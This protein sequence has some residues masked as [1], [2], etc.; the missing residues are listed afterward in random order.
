MFDPIPSR[1]PKGSSVASE[2]LF[3]SGNLT[4]TKSCNSMSPKTFK[5][6]PILK[7]CYK[8]GLINVDEEVVAHELKSFVLVGRLYITITLGR[9]VV[10]VQ[11]F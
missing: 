3:S 1:N 9:V 11:K 10:W 7:S 8:D 5:A 6:L 2:H 4:D